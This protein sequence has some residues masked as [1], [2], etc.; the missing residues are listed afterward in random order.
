MNK[1][2]W[3]EVLLIEIIIYFLLWS[4]DDYMATILSLIF[5]SMC[6]LI[7][8]IS[9]VVEMIEPSKVPR[10]YF[11]IMIVSILAPIVAFFIFSTIGGELSWM[12]K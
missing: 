10:W 7:L 3:L 1:S 12:E 6:L 4:Y 5:G 8:I 2:R 9:I 11:T